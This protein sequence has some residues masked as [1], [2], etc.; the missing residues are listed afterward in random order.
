L[1]G[2]SAPRRRRGLHPAAVPGRVRRRRPSL[3][4]EGLGA[5]AVEV[6]LDRDRFLEALRDPAARDALRATTEE[7]FRRGA[8]GVPTFFAGDRRY[9]GNDRLV[10][11]RR[12][13]QSLP[14]ET[15]RTDAAR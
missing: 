11:L 6:G 15:G 13:L 4:E 1:H 3:G 8:F 14:S 12:H 5:Y 10:L 2:G 7:A 9:W